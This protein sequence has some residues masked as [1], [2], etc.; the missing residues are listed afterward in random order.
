MFIHHENNTRDHTGG[1]RISDAVVLVVIVCIFVSPVLIL[2]LFRV[3]A[4][5][6]VVQQ[7]QIDTLETTI[8]H[9]DYDILLSSLFGRVQRDVSD[10]AHDYVRDI[11]EY[12]IRVARGVEEN[13]E[14]LAAVSVLIQDYPKQLADGYREE[15]EQLQRKVQ[16]HKQTLLPYI[17][18][19]VFLSDAVVDYFDLYPSIVERLIGQVKRNTSVDYLNAIRQDSYTLR[20]EI[21]VLY[22]RARDVLR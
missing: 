22:A 17:E 7:E 15:I 20:R 1:M 5:T 2:P 16:K 11:D 3:L 8:N 14:L 13:N 19:D 9:K 12:R 4:E 10:E 18:N 21:T 6:V